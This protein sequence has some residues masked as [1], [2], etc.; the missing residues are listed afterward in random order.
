MKKCNRCHVEKELSE[1]HNRKASEDGKS[2]TCK[3]CMKLYVKAKYYEDPQK[4][5]N[6]SKKY[7]KENRDKALLNAKIYR[8]ANL[9]KVVEYQREYRKTDK[10]KNASNKATSDWYYKNKNKHRAHQTIRRAIKKGCLIKGKICEIC[11][12]DNKQIEGHHWDY[13]KPLDVV[14]CCRKCHNK[15]H[16]Q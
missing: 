4:S 1:F 14:W 5:I 13:D 9:D 6:K 2:F 3:D 8:E 11:G 12:I 10:G 7:Y 15:I 16:S